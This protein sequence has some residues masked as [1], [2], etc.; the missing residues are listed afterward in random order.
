LGASLIPLLRT[1]R[2]TGIYRCE[3]LRDLGYQ[4]SINTS[5]DFV[6]FAVELPYTKEQPPDAIGP[7][8]MV[9]QVAS[10][11]FN[12]IGYPSVDIGSLKAELVSELREVIK[13]E[14]G[15]LEIRNPVHEG[16]TDYFEQEAQKPSVRW[17]SRISLAADGL[18][19]VLAAQTIGA[20]A[21]GAL[22]DRFIRGGS[23]SEN[24][25]QAVAPTF[26][27]PVV[28]VKWGADKR[29]Y[30]EF[31]VQTADGYRVSRSATMRIY[32]RNQEK[33]IER[34][35]NWKNSNEPP[36]NRRRTSFGWQFPFFEL[37]AQWVKLYGNPFK[38]CVVVGVSTTASEINADHS[39]SKREKQRVKNLY[40]SGSYPRLFP[41]YLQF[42]DEEPYG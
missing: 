39:L 31:A 6:D 28:G 36:A 37:D 33:Y 21:L 11:H 38:V 27:W 18:S 30:Y 7:V 25:A 17:R 10:T 19:L 34:H 29:S 13:A 42:G 1:F 24:K 16:I 15:Q 14:M 23:G 40:F 32:Y 35:P 12:N 2:F 41:V 20:F 8:N 22:T 5:S 9:I 4:I 26:S 3:R